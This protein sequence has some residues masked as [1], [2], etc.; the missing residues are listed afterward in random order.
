MEYIMYYLIFTAGAIF[1]ACCIG[2][3]NYRKFKNEKD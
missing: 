3:V 2:I 1:G